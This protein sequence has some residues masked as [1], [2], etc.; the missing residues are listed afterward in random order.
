MSS[1]LKV[2]TILPSTG[3]TVTVSGI[4]SVTSSI[5][6]GSSITGTTFYGSG[7]NL[8]SLPAQATLSN[9][10]DNR[11]ITGG[12]GVNLNGEQYLT[13]DGT[14]LNLTKSSTTAYSTTATTNDSAV[15]FINSGAAGHAT[16]QLQ[17][18]SGGSANTGQATIS[19]FNESSGSKNTA[20]TFGTRQNSDATVRERLRIDSS[21]RVMMGTTTEGNTNADDLTIANSG[22][23]GI[24]IRT[25]ASSNGNI[26][27]SDATSG[28]GEYAGIIDYKH[29]S[30]VM[31][32]GI[33]GN[34]RLRITEG[35]AEQATLV[36][37]NANTNGN[38][39]IGDN[40]TA[41]A[42]EH[43]CTIGNMY[44]GAGFFVGYGLKPKSDSWGFVSSTDAY[45]GR[46][47]SGIDA[48]EYAKQMEENG[49]GELL[50]TSMDKDGTQDG[51]DIELMSKISSKVN[52]PIIASGGVG[53]L[54][55]LVDGI[56]LGRASAVLAASIF[57][58]GKHSVK[59]AKEYLASKDIPVRI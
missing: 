41:S 56:K 53:N 16:L 26:F 31:T 1:N 20:L 51:Y 28:A 46:N 7:A 2:N 12:S 49:A 33:S 54:D 10:A 40:Y 52:I 13:F 34:E 50:V 44:S 55:H 27:F 30:N 39:W 45:G 8:T 32:F 6:A 48:L 21:G 57:H 58:Y 42:T 14:I 35:A 15:N 59:E 19:A 25:G 22:E 37:D 11:I 29:G 18:V 36:I 43:T 5:S 9:N 3:T 24:T 4:S 23:G 17:S 38:T 47:N